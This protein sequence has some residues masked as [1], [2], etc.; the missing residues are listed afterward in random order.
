MHSPLLKTRTTIALS[1]STAL[2]TALGGMAVS[3]APAWADSTTVT[4]TTAANIR[5]G[6]GTVR[7]AHGSTSSPSTPKVIGTRYATT[8]LMIRTTSGSDFK[9]LGNVPKGTRLSITGIVQNGRA[10]IIYS[11]A[12][13]WVTAQYLAASASAPSAP[14]LPRITGSRYATADLLIRT[15]PDTKYSVITTVPKG[16]LLQITG[17]TRNG[18]RQVIYRGTARW[19]TAQYLSTKRPAGTASPSSGVEKGLTVNARNLLNQARAVFPQITTYYG[20]R[21]DSIPDHPSGLALDLMVP[22]YRSA[23]GQALG[24]RITAWAQKNQPSLRIEYIIHNQHIWNVRR[25]REGWRFMA[26]RGGDTANHK[27]H[28]HIT[29]LR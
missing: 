29:V 11:G 4:E 14:A 8:T 18:R 3:A 25:A 17:T 26:D 7:T 10:Q 2:L 12:V 6:P 15:T 22:N 1:A 21:P 19:V 5:S 28:V 23:A 24:K 27:D 13:R 9:T 16:S 20:V